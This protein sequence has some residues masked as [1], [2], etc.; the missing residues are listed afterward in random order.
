MRIEQHPDQLDQLRVISPEHGATY[1]APPVFV[2]TPEFVKILDKVDSVEV[3]T[4]FGDF[5]LRKRNNIWSGFRRAGETVREYS[6]GK[7]EGITSEILD[8][9]AIRLYL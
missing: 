5:T 8:D 4:G 7:A 1:S 3:A 2:G 6:A 9:I